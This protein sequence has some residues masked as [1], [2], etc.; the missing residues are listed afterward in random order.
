MIEYQGF[1]RNSVNNGWAVKVERHYSSDN[2]GGM[3][4]V[5]ECSSYKSESVA[6]IAVKAAIEVYKAL[7]S[8][9]DSVTEWRRV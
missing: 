1:V 3:E 2:E 6:E 7:D 8:E 9:K 5:F 4:V